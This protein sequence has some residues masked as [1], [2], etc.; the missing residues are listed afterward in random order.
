MTLWRSGSELE[1]S[2]ELLKFTS[3]L[4]IDYR[5]YPYDIRASKAWAAALEEAGAIDDQQ[6]ESINRELDNIKEELDSG[7][8]EL[9][10][11]L[12]DIHMNIESILINRLGDTGARL[13]FGRSRNDQ[14]LVDVKLYLRDVL[15]ELQKN[16]TGVMKQLLDQ[17]EKNEETYMPGFT[18]LQPAQPISLAHYLMA[19][20]QKLK[21][22]FRRLR[23]C[24]DAVDVLPLGSGA[25]AGSGLA[26]NR[27]QLAQ[28]LGFSR[29]S[30]NSLD[31]VSER[32]FMVD[33]LHALSQLGIHASRLCE[34]W[35]IWASPSFGF[36][37]FD[38][39]FTTGSSIMPQKRNP[40]IAELIRGRTARPISSLHGLLTVLKAQP[41]T[42]NRDLQEDKVHLFSAID[43]VSEWLPLL[44][45]MVETMRFNS[46][47][48]SEALEKGYPEATDLAD[49]L[50]EK[51]VPFRKAHNQLREIVLM[52]IN[53]DKRLEELDLSDYHAVNK[54]FEEDLFELL[55]PAASL[56]R[57]DLPGGTGPVSVKN[58]IDA[59]RTWLLDRDYL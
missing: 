3:S 58:Q 32:D 49:Y 1:P 51:G 56:S 19:F 10:P 34:D 40:D 59:A 35:I 21:R 38:D 23:S 7:E 6:R 43:C 22:D 15:I 31:A 36:C 24:F 44:A 33:I 29:I 2:S 46:E 28:E 12:E 48:M 27:E 26:I 52:A 45:G 20:F 17:A 13:H 9:D 57:R 53:K 37:E 30:E 14:V 11:E 50:V 5:L 25:L 54:Q 18:H 55:S 41:L 42:Y 16:V 8:L 47:R 4:E 39:K